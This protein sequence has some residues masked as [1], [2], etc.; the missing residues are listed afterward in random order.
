MKLVQGLLKE[1]YLAPGWGGRRPGRNSGYL[2]E[3]SASSGG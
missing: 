1:D 3:A 2:S